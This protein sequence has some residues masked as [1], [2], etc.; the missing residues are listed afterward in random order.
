LQPKTIDVE[1]CGPMNN[2]EPRHRDHPPE[3]QELESD[4]KGALADDD[5]TIDDDRHYLQDP[6]GLRQNA[7]DE[8]ERHQDELLELDQTELDELGL[9]LDDPHQPEP[10]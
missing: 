9:R 8:D 7:R 4:A 1:E 10:E 2:D 3:R 6:D 5:S